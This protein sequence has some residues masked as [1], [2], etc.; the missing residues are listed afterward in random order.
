MC[1]RDRV[2]AVLVSPGGVARMIIAVMPCGVG[3]FLVPVIAQEHADRLIVPV[4]A[5]DYLAYVCLLYTSQTTRL[6]S[7]LSPLPLIKRR[8]RRLRLPLNR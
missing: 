3:Q 2:I 8:N 6:F 1:I 5:Y 7:R 4:G